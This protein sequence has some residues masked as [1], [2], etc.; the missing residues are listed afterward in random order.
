MRLAGCLG[1]QQN[2]VV[3]SVSRN[4]ARPKLLTFDCVKQILYDFLLWPLAHEEAQTFQCLEGRSSDGSGRVKGYWA[5]QLQQK[6][7][8]FR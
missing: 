8:C 2:E 5:Y 3:I 7:I 1:K 4:S 6:L